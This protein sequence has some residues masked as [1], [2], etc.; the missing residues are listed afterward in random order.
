MGAVAEGDQKSL[1]LYAYSGEIKVM[2][3][4]TLVIGVSLLEKL[5]L[6]SYKFNV[7]QSQKA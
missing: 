6:S 3:L 4:N 2:G 5:V 1:L 7:I